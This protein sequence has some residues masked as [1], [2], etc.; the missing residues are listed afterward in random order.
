MIGLVPVARLPGAPPILRAAFRNE[1]RFAGATVLLAVS[2]LPTLVAYAFDDRLVGGVPAWTKPLKFQAALVV[3]LATLAWYAAWMPRGFAARLLYRVF[4][5]A[6][7]V[8]VALEIVWIAGAAA[9]GVA[10][11]FNVATRGMARIYSLM[12]VLAF[13]LTS[14]SLVLGLAILRARDAGGDPVLR[15]AIGIGLTMTFALT[16]LAAGSLSGNSGHLIGID[17]ATVHRLPVLGWARNGGDLRVAHFLATH[18]MHAIP[19]AGLIAA[20]LLAPAAARL[21]VIICSLVYA[22]LVAW[23]FAEALAGRPFL[24]FLG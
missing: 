9:F 8:A 21:A 12:G 24:P 19:L 16:V 1:P 20:R 2:M 3:Y 14:A 18:A 22:M 7:V 15:L 11:H 17:A 4:S 23:T 13:L 10:S 6:V 5:T